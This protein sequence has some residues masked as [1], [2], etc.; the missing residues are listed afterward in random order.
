MCSFD[1]ELHK[2]TGS[3]EQQNT[4]H[5]HCFVLALSQHQST[6]VSSKLNSPEKMK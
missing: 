1:A 5:A 2:E 3:V 4:K 6:I